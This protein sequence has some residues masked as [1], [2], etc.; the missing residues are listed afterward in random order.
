MSQP[1]RVPLA[2]IVSAAAFGCAASNGSQALDAPPAI[3]LPGTAPAEWNTYTDAVHRFAVS[4]PDGLGILPEKT[5]PPGGAVA[6]VR[7]QDTQILSGAFAELEP[8]RLTIEVF[9]AKPGTPLTDWLR[10]VNR[11]PAA[12][13]TTRVA[14]RGAAE[15]VRVQERRQLAPNDF[16]YVAAGDRVYVLTPLGGYS[17]EMLASFRLP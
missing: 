4:Y 14:L 15:A 17:A 12:A 1:G 7:F 9:A 10:S 3:L 11:L 6:R 2:L 8:P 16:Y 13:T 5:S